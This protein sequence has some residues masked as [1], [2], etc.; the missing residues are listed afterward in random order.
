MAIIIEKKRGINI[1]I[2][3]NEV[4][5]LLGYNTKKKKPPEKI[6]QMLSQERKKLKSLLTPKATYHI[7]DKS[8]IKPH[9]VF[10]EAEKIAICICT[11]G[12]KLEQRVSNLFQQNEMLRG[13]ILDALGSEATEQV[14]NWANSEICH[15]AAQ[16]KLKGSRRLSPGYGKW[17]IEEQDYIFSLLP[18]NAIGVSLTSSMMMIPRKSISFAIKLR[19]KGYKEDNK[20]LCKNCNLRLT[21]LY[22]RDR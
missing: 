15:Q 10:N 7:F 13:L 19:I 3:D 22:R 11:I 5:R 20:S 8:E 18:A 9:I 21:C 12:R 1:N 2:T 16:L 4:I 17:G 14:A 6:Y